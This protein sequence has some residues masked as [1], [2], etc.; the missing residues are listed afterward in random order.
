MPIIHTRDK[1]GNKIDKLAC[2]EDI[3]REKTATNNY[4]IIFINI[5]LIMVLIQR[6]GEKKEIEHLT[7]EE[8]K[9]NY[10]L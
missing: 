4:K 5:L 6:K 9:A 1:N 3:G 7:T 10:K 8:I 2:S